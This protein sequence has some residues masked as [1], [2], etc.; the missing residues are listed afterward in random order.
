M[1]RSTKFLTQKPW[2][3]YRSKSYVRSLTPAGATSDK[4]AITYCGCGIAATS[5]AF[6]LHLLGR[7]GV[8]V[9]DGSIEVWSSDP[10]L[11]ME[12]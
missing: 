1:S 2:P 10:N 3:T 12:K 11:P 6:A 5:D 4:Q 8:A 7:D 9:Y